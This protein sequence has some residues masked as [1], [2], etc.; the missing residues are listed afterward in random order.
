MNRRGF[1]RSLIASPL[2]S[3]R[4]QQDPIAALEG[5]LERKRREIRIRDL[6]NIAPAGAN[7][8]SVADMAGWLRLM[9]NGGVFDGNV[10]YRNPGSGN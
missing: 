6:T 5:A 10:W 9:L 7:N 4:T 3:V 1:I 2:I 8:S